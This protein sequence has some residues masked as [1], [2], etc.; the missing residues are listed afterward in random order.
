M[1][2]NHEDENNDAFT[3]RRSPV[4]WRAKVWR[5]YGRGHGVESAVVYATF[6]EGREAARR[7]RRWMQSRYPFGRWVCGVVPVRRTPG[8]LRQFGPP[9]G[10]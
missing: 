2:R 3:T 8:D 10:Q 4:G 7:L 6:S 9:G 5:H 1:P